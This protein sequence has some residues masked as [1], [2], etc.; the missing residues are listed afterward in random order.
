ML[1]R[2]LYETV[3][4]MAA[5]LDELGVDDLEDWRG[6]YAALHALQVQARA[7]LDMVRRLASLLGYSPETPRD[8]ARIL[9]GEGVLS[10]EEVGLIRRV[11]GFRNIV[12]HEYLGVDVGLVKRIVLGREYRRL[13]GLAARLLEKAEER[14]L[15]DP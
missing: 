6:L 8:A 11:A 4:E 12:V 9:R 7:L 3:A 1:L 10:D 15:G 14:G 13:V 2:R 5:R